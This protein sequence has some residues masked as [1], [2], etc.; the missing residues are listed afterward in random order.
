[1]KFQKIT[2]KM[3]WS[4]PALRPLTPTDALLRAAVAGDP[5]FAAA[6]RRSAQKA[7]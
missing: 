2:P 5:Q 3:S 1:M 6:V 7:S 4:T